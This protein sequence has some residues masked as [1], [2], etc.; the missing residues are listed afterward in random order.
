M[1]PQTGWECLNW[2]CEFDHHTE[3]DK[4]SL[5]TKVRNCSLCEPWWSWWDIATGYQRLAFDILW[6]VITSIRWHLTSRSCYVT[7]Q[8]QFTPSKCCARGRCLHFSLGYATVFKTDE[9][10]T[11][12]HRHSSRNT[13]LLHKE[14][15]GVF[16]TKWCFT[17]HCVMP[18]DRIFDW[19]H[20]SSSW[21]AASRILLVK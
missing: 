4:L 20:N 18:R 19:R 13:Y 9:S 2:V 14:Q 7:F 8:P 3:F 16:L 21:S 6:I 15:D 12:N 5:I 10:R 17:W 11:E 1:L